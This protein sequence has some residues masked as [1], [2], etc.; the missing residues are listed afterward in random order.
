[1]DDT[2]LLALINS[3]SF[4]ND[5]SLDEK[6]TIVKLRFDVVRFSPSDLI[7]K[8]GEFEETFYILLKGDAQVIKA[9]K[10]I[11]ILKP[12]A[13]FG[14]LSWLGKKA[15][16]SSVVA[17]T[18]VVAFRLD[19]KKV[20]KFEPIIRDKIKDKIIVNLIS[21]LENMNKQLTNQNRT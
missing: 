15:R 16:I 13:L 5:F 6:K 20:Q 11:T 21:R 7:I 14:E 4:F 19:L 1:L 18:E 10:V 9:Q 2:T 8:E 17:A 3:V 12:G